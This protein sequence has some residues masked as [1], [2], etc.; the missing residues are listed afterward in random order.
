MLASEF[1]LKIR[2]INS[3]KNIFNIFTIVSFIGIL[4]IVG[5]VDKNFDIPEYEM[6]VAVYDSTR[7]ITVNEFINL[8]PELGEGMVYKIDSVYYIKAVVTANDKSGNLYK[9]MYVQDET[10][11]LEIQLDKTSLFNV[12]PVGQIVYLRCKDFYLGNYSGIKQFGYDYNGGPGRIPTHLIDSAIMLDGLPDINNAPEPKTVSNVGAGGG[13]SLFSDISKLVKITNVHFQTPGN[14]YANE[15]ENYPERTVYDAFGNA[16]I[17]STSTY[18]KFAADTIPEGFGDITGILS[19]Y[20]GEFRLYIR[21]IEDVQMYNMILN[22]KFPSNP[23][24]WT[25]VN[26]S[27]TEAWTFNSA[28]TCMKIN[29]WG[30]NTG[31]PNE[32]WLISPSFD[33]SSS[34]NPYLTFSNRRRFSDTETEPMT[35]MVTTNYTGDVTT[36]DWTALSAILDQNTTSTFTAWVESGEVDLSEHIGSNV[37]IAFRYKSSGNG[38]GTASY[39]DIDNVYVIDK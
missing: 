34:V 14:L 4:S 16:M 25:T 20:N 39:W 17:L 5:C 37:R 7:L 18:A 33:I 35:V 15:G 27:G 11:G 23:T 36:T 21:G 13:L 38:S 2:K 22:E 26:V 29:G 24:N 28:D 12:Y 1:N 9:K 19:L 10:G 6:P 30:S 3:M 31:V 8:A 32:D